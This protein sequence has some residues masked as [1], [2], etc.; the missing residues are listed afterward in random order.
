MNSLANAFLVDTFFGSGPRHSRWPW[1]AAFIGVGLVAV[2]W[3]AAKNANVP[4]DLA[5][6][7][8]FTPIAKLRAGID[9]QTEALKRAAE[10]A[11]PPMAP[12][13]LIPAQP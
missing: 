3:H 6:K 12:A 1:Y 13:A 7:H 8:P 9:A 4:T 10:A 2:R 11:T 5:F